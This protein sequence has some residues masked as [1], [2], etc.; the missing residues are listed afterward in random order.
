MDLIL[1][2]I[3]SSLQ[4]NIYLNLPK[5]LNL[6]KNVGD[7]KLTSGATAMIKKNGTV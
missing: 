6:V 2:L 5:A 1:C 4:I 7:L 3:L